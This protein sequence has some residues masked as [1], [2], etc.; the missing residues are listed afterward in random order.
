MPQSFVLKFVFFLHPKICLHRSKFSVREKFHSK[1][2]YFLLWLRTQIFTLSLGTYKHSMFLSLSSKCDQIGQFIGLYGN[3]SKLL[4]TINSPKS[5]TFLAI[6][7]K[8]LKSLIF[9]VKS[10]FGN[11]YR[12]LA[13][14]YWSCC[15]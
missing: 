7:V 11:F 4:A 6:F 9:L 1:S 14:F 2:N 5:S 12:H 15:L 13:T 3:F 8:V 10:F